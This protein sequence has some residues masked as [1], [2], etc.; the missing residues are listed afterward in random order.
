MRAVLLILSLLAGAA[1]GDRTLIDPLAQLEKDP[2][3]ILLAAQPTYQA[4]YETYMTWLTV[5]GGIP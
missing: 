4:T 2:D 5:S 1:C 3:A